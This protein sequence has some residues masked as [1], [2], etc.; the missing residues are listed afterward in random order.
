M[1]NVNSEEKTVSLSE[2]SF[3]ELARMRRE[4]QGADTSAT[5]E[6]EEIPAEEEPAEEIELREDVEVSSDYCKVPNDM[7]KVAPLQDPKEHC[8]YQYMYRLSYGWRRNFCRCGYG[9]IVK[10]TSLS[11]RSSAIRAVEGLMEKVHI[12]RIEEETHSKAGSL[13]RLLSPEEILSSTFKSSIVNMSM[14]RLIISDE[15]IIRMKI[16]R[17]DTERPRNEHSQND[18]SRQNR[19]AGGSAT[20][21]KLNI[22]ETAR[23][24]NSPSKNKGKTT[25]A[26]SNANNEPDSTLVVV[27]SSDFFSDLHEGTVRE[28]C[29]EFGPDK[30]SE[31]VRDLDE[32]YK[33]K[34]VDN[35]GGLLREALRKDYTPP[36]RVVTRRKAKE[37]REKDEAI[38]KEL[39]CQEAAARQKIADKKAKLT[40]VERKKLRQQALAEI[41]HSDYKKEFVTEQLV[42]AVENEILGRE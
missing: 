12:I 28:L 23:D 3:A 37:Q 34:T 29:T 36:K 18:N 17:P 26:P 8:V 31:K 30:V 6:A 15:T 38:Q 11:S 10:N 39:E 13:Y 41:E 9:G 20:M 42:E 25:E 40:Q 35:P 21:T 2:L 24:K 16:V 5:A 33:G 7:Q 19:S 4:R 27:S 22:V 1:Q 32:Q 14:V